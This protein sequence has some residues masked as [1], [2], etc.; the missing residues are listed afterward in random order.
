MAEIINDKITYC[1]KCK[2]FISYTKED[3]KKGEHIYYV[4]G[5]EENYE[6][7]TYI[8][9]PKCNKEIELHKDVIKLTNK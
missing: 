1:P 3:T 4:Y 8:N 5:C 6:P 7:Y 9:C 2:K